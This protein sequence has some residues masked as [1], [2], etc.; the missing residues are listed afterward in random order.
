MAAS[1]DRALAARFY[2]ARGD[3]SIIDAVMSQQVVWDITPGFP[4]GGIY[5]GL[6]AVLTDF[7]GPVSALFASM[8]AQPATLLADGDGHVT[9]IGHYA[10]TGRDGAAVDCRFV[11]VWTVVDGK[12]SHLH[13]TADSHLLY[14]LIGEPSR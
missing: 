4:R 8:A 13:Q 12:L 3:R 9:V 7:L 14:G 1:D 10:V 6:D 11:H 2:E 5:E